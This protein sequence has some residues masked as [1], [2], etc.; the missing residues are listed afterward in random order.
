MKTSKKEIIYAFID[1]QNLY[2]GIKSLGWEMDYHKLFVYLKEKH[3]VNKAIIYIGYLEKNIHLYSYLERCG[4]DL[5]FKNTKQYGKGRN[6]IKGNI[7][8]DL[9]V[10]AVRKCDEYSSAVFI[11]ADGDFCALYDY[12]IDEKKKDLIII[13]PNRYKY[14][15]FLLKYRKKLKFMN[16]LEEKLGIKK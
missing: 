12:L 7:D 10:D 6:Q 8:V 16:D 3:K 9:T 1:N 13:I 4:F 15:G 2:L 14:S 5:V 11:S